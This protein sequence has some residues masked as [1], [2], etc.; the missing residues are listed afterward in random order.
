L[1]NYRQLPGSEPVYSRNEEAQ[2]DSMPLL[3]KDVTL[4]ATLSQVDNTY[5]SSED[6]T[7]RG[8][9]VVVRKYST[10]S[11]VKPISLF[12]KNLLILNNFCLG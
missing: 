7:R 5:E 3:L 4:L 10:A 2:K 6:V 8:V 12:S 9:I 11:K 1:K